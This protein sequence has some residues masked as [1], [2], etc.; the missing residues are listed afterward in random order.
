VPDER[1]VHVAR[2]FEVLDDVDVPDVWEAIMARVDTE[3][4]DLNHHMRR[5]RRW[6]PVVV[7][8]AALLIVAVVVLVSVR[9]ADDSQTVD[10]P[11]LPADGAPNTLE[12]IAN[13]A[14]FDVQGSLVAGTVSIA[15]RNIGDGLHSMVIGRLIDGKTLED[16]RDA[17]A[18]AGPDVP[19]ALVGI[20]EYPSP[21]PA[22]GAWRGPGVASTLTVSGVASGEYVLANVPRDNAGLPIWPQAD[23]QSLTIAAGDSDPGP[24]PDATYTVSADGLDGPTALPAGAT[25]ISF[26][27]DGTPRAL[28]VYRATQRP[29]DI[30]TFFES[31]GS[32]LDWS[33]AP[34]DSFTSTPD[35]DADPVI[36][37]ELTPGQW[38]FHLGPDGQQEQPSQFVVISVL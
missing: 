23:V 13:G 21:L 11:P 22:L 26:D 16:A 27:N 2:L 36:S 30:G 17:V 33:H 9:L 37:L 25:T 14:D 10:V 19:D 7:A 6:W 15:G 34:F 31:A 32:P 3:P 4:T 18:S 38:L 29:E 28:S 24:V 8:A 35:T 12:V 5:S 20:L 1:D